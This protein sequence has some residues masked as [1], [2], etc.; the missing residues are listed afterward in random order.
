MSLSELYDTGYEPGEPGFAGGN[1]P[2]LPMAPYSAGPND[3]LYARLMQMAQPAAPKV[4]KPSGVEKAVSYLAP[5]INAWGQ[6]RRELSWRRRRN[7]FL[8]NLATGGIGTALAAVAAPRLQREALAQKTAAAN[9]QWFEN[10][11][12]LAQVGTEM[13][14]AQNVGGPPNTYQDLL[15][16]RAQAGDKTAEDELRKLSE[17]VGEHVEMIPGSGV[18]SISRGGEATPVTTQEA[19]PNILGPWAESVLGPEMPSKT[20]VPLEVP[21]KPNR[22]QYT[23]QMARDANGKS[24]P[25]LVDMDQN[26]DTFGQPFISTAQGLQP[27]TGPVEQQP[28]PRKGTQPK[29]GTP[30]QFANLDKWKSGELQKAETAFRDPAKPEYGDRDALEARKQRVY[31]AYDQQ[32]ASLQGAAGGGASAGKPSGTRPKVTMHPDGT[33]TVE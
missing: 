29:R 25:V 21:Q 23:Q 13:Q 32:Q 16:R 6:S 5:L 11:A 33:I 14:R 19:M 18:Y 8:G 26:S 10:L 28:L 3:D 20:Q 30:A 4:E 27:Y 1:P 17:G 9:Q 24:I 22:F 2:T 7:A 15:A 31:S 12:K